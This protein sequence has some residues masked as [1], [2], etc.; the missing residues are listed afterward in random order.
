MAYT[1]LSVLKDY[2]GVPSATSSEDTPLTAAMNAAQDLVD[3]Y[4]NTTFETVTEARVYRA[5]DPDLLLVDQFRT[6]TGL[7]VK[8]DTNNDGTYDTTLTITTDYLAT[9]FNEP[10]FTGLLNVSDEWPRY[11]SGRPAVQVTAAYGDQNSNGV[12]YA[13]QQAALILAARLYQRKASP[14]GIMTG[15]Q[16]YGIARI[17]RQDPDVA[18][19]LAQ[20][21]VLATA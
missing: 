13:V 8:T 3:G 9:P 14:L 10:P 19:L 20:Y 21:R 5:D 6:L 11:D 2:L 7:V 17:S 16:D 15:F 18:A 4:C 1:S 12:P